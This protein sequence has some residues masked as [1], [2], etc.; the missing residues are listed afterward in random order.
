MAQVEM[1]FD[2]ANILNHVGIP[3]SSEDSYAHIFNVT[4]AQARVILTRYN[5]KN[6]PQRHGHVEQLAREDFELVS[7]SIG[8]DEEGNLFD[9]QHRLLACVEKNE[10]IRVTS[11]FGIVREKAKGKQD[12]GRK[13]TKSDH[14]N[15]DGYTNSGAL[16]AN[17]GWLNRILTGPN[18]I[19]RGT[20]LSND[21]AIK[22][23][24]QHPNLG[25]MILRMNKFKPM[26]S[27]ISCVTA[28][29]YVFEHYATYRPDKDFDFNDFLLGVRDGVGLQQYDP[30]LLLREKLMKIKLESSLQRIR[31]VVWHQAVY[32]IRAWNSFYSG[33][34]PKSLP[35]PRMGGQPVPFIRGWRFC[36]WPKEEAEEDSD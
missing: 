26:C 24:A 7:A 27:S 15:V 9:G 25:S 28:C 11:T 29:M 10:P 5:P 21:D 18:A 1:R 19:V 4:P 33:R 22:M 8:F 30:R 17:L 6:R 35:L 34:T 16:A 20:P 2:P 13:R 14:L 3:V 12:N 36:P 32:T 31:P 23:A